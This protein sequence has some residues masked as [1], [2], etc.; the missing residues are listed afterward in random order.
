[1]RARTYRNV[2]SIVL[3]VMAA[4]ALAGCL[5]P[6]EADPTGTV[7]IGSLERVV[8]MAGGFRVIGWAADPDTAAPV[9]VSV[10]SEQRL[11]KGTADLVRYDVGAAYPRLGAGHGYDIRYQGLTPGRHQLCVWVDNVG[12]GTQG[13]LLGCT[14]VTVP[15]P[16]PIGSLDSV[17]A[18]ND[19]TVRVGG[20]ALD[21]DTTDPIEVTA[22]LDGGKVMTSTAKVARPD[23]D[24]VYGLGAAHGFAMDL[25]AS[26][27]RHSV[28]VIGHNVG[29]GDHAWIGCRD[30]VVPEAQPDRRPTGSV[31][32]VEPVGS[33]AVRVRGLATDPDT[34]GPVTIRVAVDGNVRT[35]STSG[36]AFDTTISGLATGSHTVC[37]TALDVAYTG[38]APVTSG[39]RSW[40]CGTVILGSVS[41]GSS[42]APAGPPTPVGPES[43]SP[44]ATID[45]D[46]GVSVQLRDGSVLWLFGDSSQVDAAGNLKYFVNNTAAWAPAGTPTVTSDAAPGGV[47]VQFVSP[48]GSSWTCPPER[49]NK[50]MWPTAAVRTDAGGG[51]DLVTA[52]FGNVCLG[53]SWLDIEGRGQA[54]AQWTYDPN[55]KPI[56]QPIQATSVLNHELFSGQDFAQAATT[57]TVSGTTYIYGYKCDTPTDGPGVEWPTEFGPCRVGRVPVQSVSTR[58][59]WRFWNGSSWVV[60]SA[61]AVGIT[62][63]PSAEDPRAPVAGATVT[64]DEVHDVYVMGYSPWPGFTD[65]IFVRVATAPEGPWSDV[66]TVTLPGCND[67]IGANGYYCYAGTVQPELSEPGLLGLGYYD[68]LVAVGPNR[69]QY[70]TV[71]VPFKVVLV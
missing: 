31:T 57:R 19:R 13:R 50:A 68:Q 25:P 42:G 15:A 59:T 71:K 1:M 55:N 5:G 52:F 51:R 24:A 29:A 22:L 12:A 61:Q 8:P 64:W 49:P 33:S 11:V 18:L 53:S 66:V 3:A 43:T 41:V 56:G 9:A 47:P 54:V 45:R 6:G 58:S 4:G 10:S 39:D 20:W 23:V 7:P 16:D 40:P 30:V 17:A 46:A 63:G 35:I 26:P 38:T 21:P 67:T 36:G 28:C 37:V 32:A 14:Y 70:V 60:D 34:S 2:W 44:I 69:G 27:G 65:R 62:P 48:A